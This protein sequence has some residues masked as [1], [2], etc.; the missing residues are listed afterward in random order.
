M[1]NS[2]ELCFLPKKLHK[3]EIV[4]EKMEDTPQ[5]LPDIEKIHI[6]PYMTNK[7]KH[8]VKYTLP[9]AAMYTTDIFHIPTDKCAEFEN[10]MLK[11][12]EVIQQKM[13][14]NIEAKSFECIVTI[15]LCQLQISLNT[16]EVP[17]LIRKI[18]TMIETKVVT[19]Q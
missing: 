18:E 3:K 6:Y 4:V 9:E 19:I 16:D 13:L 2:V 1:F 12:A 8:I 5:I 14:N 11:W 10:R 17:F 15:E 7:C